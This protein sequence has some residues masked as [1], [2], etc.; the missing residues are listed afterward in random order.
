MLHVSHIV[1]P[2]QDV[3]SCSSDIAFNSH[4]L[5]IS[6]FGFLSQVVDLGFLVSIFLPEVWLE[7]QYHVLLLL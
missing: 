7:D 1:K 2:S 6:W 3:L 4:C 5:F